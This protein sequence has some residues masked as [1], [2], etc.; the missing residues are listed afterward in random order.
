MKPIMI[1]G[2]FNCQ[3]TM[4]DAQRVFAKVAKKIF[5]TSR[6]ICVVI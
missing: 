6:M 2:K 1:N 3:G 5:E 4:N